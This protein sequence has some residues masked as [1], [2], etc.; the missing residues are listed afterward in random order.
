MQNERK[1]L[2]LV[3]SVINNGYSSPSRAGDTYSLPGQQITVDL[4]EG[5]PIM[6]TRKIFTEG[7]FGELAAFVRGAEDLAT[8]RK[9][10][11][12]YWNDNAANWHANKGK[13]ESEWRVGRIYGAQWV[14][15]QKNRMRQ[16]PAPELR[17]GLERTFLGV[18][19]GSG[20]IDCPD[21][22]KTWQGLLTRCYNQ[23]FEMY[24]L[25]GGRGVYVVD[26]W[27][28][29]KAF[30][31]DA[32]LLPGWSDKANSTTS[33][34]YQLDKDIL[35]DGF[36][37][38]PNTCKWASASENSHTANTRKYTVQ[39]DDGE[40]FVFTNAK[41]FCEE[42][43][44]E[45]KN[46]CDL[47]TGRK[48]AKIRYGYKL[49]DVQ[50]IGRAAAINQLAEVIE[51]I[52]RDPYSRR[53]ILT[54]WK[55]DELDEMA[56]P[57]C[58]LICQFYARQEFLHCH[59]YM[60]SVDLCVGLPSDIVLYALLMHLVAKDVGLQPATLT[61]SFGD[62]HL[63]KNHVRQFI[64]EQSTRLIHEAPK[65]QLQEQATTL[66]FEPNQAWLVGYTHEPAMKYAFN[67]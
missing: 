6:T 29:F 47:W 66:T 35:G 10:G 61:F 63:Y 13:P 23:K 55:P 18:G 44:I 21:L 42:H 15:W 62:C 7:V 24:H 40:V 38:G 25:Y 5:F 36:V 46:F 4:R 2:D 56:L 1:Y 37:Y 43:N 52:K 65:L 50:H 60:R 16:Q 32:K 49:L 28:E 34:A 57:P 3:W 11:C 8:F 67:A 41:A 30:A 12:N 20:G 9:F 17:P 26:R 31:E 39:R 33:H 45:G 53:H 19:N 54:T 27:L 22:V 14:N 64:D 51:N 58:H 48:N 59:V